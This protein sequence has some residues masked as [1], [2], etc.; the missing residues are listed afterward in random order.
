MSFKTILVHVDRTPTAGNRVKAA[1]HLAK[2]EGASLIGLTAAMPQ[3]PIAA[4]S[5]V[6]V[7]GVASD[8]FVSDQARIDDDF[9][10]CE[11]V[12][13]QGTAD[14]DLQGGW[15][16]VREMPVAA[17]TE[18]GNSADLIVI[19]RTDP[20]TFNS[21]GYLDAGELLLQSGRPVLIVPPAHHAIDVRTA[22]VAWKSTREARRAISDALPALARAER[23][24]LLTIDEGGEPDPTVPDAQ[25]FLVRHGV[26]VRS[27]RIER[28]TATVDEALVRFAT[29]VQADLIVAGAYGHTRIREWVFG[30]VTRRLVMNSPLPCILSH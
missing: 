7:G 29:T 8:L 22:I 19:G 24:V 25:G 26:H 3:A 17:L 12:F 6:G 30:G 15:R 16:A 14:F 27:Q 13:R 28:G 18:A 5:M 9:A 2:R 21:S 11:A 20:S 1:A 4:A 10:T 23:V